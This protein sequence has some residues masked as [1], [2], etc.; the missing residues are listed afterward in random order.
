MVVDLKTFNEF[1]L[2]KIPIHLKINDTKV[3][4]KKIGNGI[5]LIPYHDP[6]QSFFNFCGNF[7][8]DFMNEREQGK[9]ERL[10]KKEHQ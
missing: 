3:F 7:S 9:Q 1:Q 2:F 5:L 8:D 10:E 6:W 4:I